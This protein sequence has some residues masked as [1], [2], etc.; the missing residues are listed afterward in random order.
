M[1]SLVFDIEAVAASHINSLSMH[2][3]IRKTTGKSKIDPARSYLNR[4]LYGDG[5]TV[6]DTLKNWY[7][8]TGSKKPTKQ[9][10]TPYFT[11]VIGA[12]P[13]YFHADPENL[14][15]FLQRSMDWLKA[16]FGDDLV[17]AELHLDET[18]PHIHVLVAPTYERKNRVPGK[19]KKGETAA[20]F[21]AR[22]DV[23]RN[24]PGLR[25]VARTSSRWAYEGSYEAMR[26]SLA[27]AVA[28]LGIEY[29]Q[30]RQVRATSKAEY[31]KNLQA[32]LTAKEEDL[33]RRE[34]DLAQREATY[35]AHGEYLRDIERQLTNLHVS[36]GD[37]RTSLQADVMKFSDVKARIEAQLAEQGQQ[38]AMAFND[39]ED[40]LTDVDHARDK[41][42]SNV[43]RFERMLGAMRTSIPLKI[44]QS[45]QQL[46]D[47]LKESLGITKEVVMSADDKLYKIRPGIK[48]GPSR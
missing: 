34:A 21:E 7:L 12:S 37:K 33:G 13:E 32:S 44:W 48:I 2:C 30:D 15:Q 9:A 39:V 17:F 1:A 43:M 28:D 38:L 22:K 19:V 10:E 25:T 42:M 47:D 20:E 46:I 4:R 18:T 36:V 45:L 8:R 29:G 24:A 41:M 3:A 11:F 14:E 26:R 35:S 23:A 6:N 31:L 27:Q 40:A 16:E 5:A